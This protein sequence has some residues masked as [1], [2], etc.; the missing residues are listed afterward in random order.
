MDVRQKSILIVEDTEFERLILSEIL[1]DMGVANIY[2]A[3]DGLEG[4]RAARYYK[5]DLVLLDIGLPKIDGFE[6]CKKIRHFANK[7]TLP[8]IVIT[9]RDKSES[10]EKI[11]DLGAN[12]YFEKPFSKDEI[13][14]RILFYLEYS[15]MF[16]KLG[17]MERY[18][19]RDIKVAKSVQRKT[20][21]SLNTAVNRLRRRGI[22][23]YAYIDESNLGGDSWGLRYLE[24]DTPVFFI[25]D[26]TGHG[27][28][29]AIN[30]SFITGFAN[31]VFREFKNCPAPDFDP[32]SFLQKL[33]AI[34]CD[35]SQTETFCTAACFAV[36]G[37]EVRYAGCG[38][39]EIKTLRMTDG[40]LESWPCHGL[41]LGI[42]S[43]NFSPT[44]GIIHDFDE[45]FILAMTDGLI[46]SLPGGSSVQNFGTGPDLL[47]GETFLH[48]C[49]GQIYQE[50][51]AKTPE[52]IIQSILYNF[53]EHG[54]NLLSDDITVLALRGGVCREAAP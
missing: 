25:F 4:V 50:S 52:D 48:T 39:P 3:K 41:P 40:S 31:S 21:P 30:N 13:K 46:E 34:I 24:D 29:A 47:P 22:D 15:E 9:G 43:A 51:D 44:R 16:Q 23:F 37:S 19:N 54:F 35:N 20:L 53:S 12:D 32:V 14:N 33:N 18:L 5:P 7:M 26:V 6:V 11:F 42:S 36:D 49:L 2:A 1:K 28:N 8:V 10:L 38:L 27:I 17:E 45:K